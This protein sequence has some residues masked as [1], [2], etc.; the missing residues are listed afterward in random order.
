MYNTANMFKGGYVNKP[1]SAQ[2]FRYAGLLVA[3]ILTIYGLVAQREVINNTYTV[4][5]TCFIIFSFWWFYLGII[6]YIFPI[7]GKLDCYLRLTAY[8]LLAGSYLIFI[9]GFT[10]PITAIWLILT[11]ASF[12]YLSKLGYIL[13]I[14]ALIVFVAFDVL[15]WNG[16]IADDL[17]T[18]FA[19][20]ITGL[21]IVVVSGY[22][23]ISRKELSDSKAQ[24]SCLLYTSPS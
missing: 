21:V 16:I 3:T 19:I 15:F 17:T 13:D 11:L 8:H 20:A 1:R 22:Q 9:S 6:H 14:L 18:V 7:K 24:E 23:E 2:V 12:V 5:F 4:D 10:S